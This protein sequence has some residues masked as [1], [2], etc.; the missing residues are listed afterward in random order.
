M[1][2]LWLGHLA[3]DLAS[4]ALP[5]VLVFL[6]PVLHLSYTR[7]GAAVLVATV[8][9]SIA[10]P[11]FGR[12][13]DRHAMTWLVP[14][15]IATSAAGIAAAALA[16]DYSWLLVAVFFSGLGV[17]LFHPEAMK[18]ARHAS[19]RRRASGLT[20]FQ[21]GGNLGI[22]LGPLLAGLVLAASGSTGGLILLVPGALVT[23]L[24]LRDFGSLSRV[25]RSGHADAVREV[26]VDR[27]G[28]FKVLL[29]TVAFR[30]VA[31]YGL[32]TFVPLW[33]V[34]RGHS[35]SYGAALLS[36][37]LFG[38]AI[39]TLCSGPLA[40]RHGDKVV[41][42][43]SLALTPALLVAFV[44]GNGVLAVIALTLA[45]ALLVSGFGLTTFMG[46]E[47]L[48]SRIATA[49]GMTVGLT[50]G[51][52][53]VAAVLLGVVADAV[54]LRFA[55]LAT[56]AA[57]AAGALVALLLPRERARSSSAAPATS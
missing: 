27:V 55:L 46:Q 3:A 39:G 47:F 25:R 52:G 14:V 6:K 50:T 24:V 35:T 18:L 56:A 31:Y 21:T 9:S 45:G 34:E 1:A 40:D 2:E 5:A 44:L 4:G 30:S 8:T 53:G 49:S 23:L 26:P 11:V 42:A 13:S 51:L 29:A 17:G 36:L 12:W 32:F 43:G 22:A 10:Q 37:V 41:L 57:P 33:E 54:D 15:G 19:G 38:G 48:P 16:H 20:I 7:A 28:P